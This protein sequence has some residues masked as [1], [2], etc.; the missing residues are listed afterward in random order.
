MFSSYKPSAATNI[1]NLNCSA[2]DHGELQFSGTL[3]RGATQAPP[4]LQQQQRVAQYHQHQ[5]D[6][7]EQDQRQDDV[8]L[9]RCQG[10]EGLISIKGW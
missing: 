3:S 6:E 1:V 5:R 4:H 2:T 10:K 8:Q 9:T 7:E